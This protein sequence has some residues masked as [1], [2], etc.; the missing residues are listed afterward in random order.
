MACSS[1]DEVAANGM[2]AG[3][4]SGRL[5]RRRKRM[6]RLKAK[7]E[8]ARQ[9]RQ[10]RKELVKVCPLPRHCMTSAVLVQKS[11]QK[12]GMMQHAASLKGQSKAGSPQD[13][14]LVCMPYCRAAG[15][16]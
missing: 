12:G 9:E 14:L 13:F 3:R 2:V 10:A 16:L 8:V 11:Q 1:D 6:E 4:G 15:L 7:E 5:A